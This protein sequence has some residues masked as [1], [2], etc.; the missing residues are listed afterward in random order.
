M[1][2]KQPVPGE[3]YRHFKRGG[4]YEVVGVARHT[5]TEEMLVVYRSLYADSEFPFGTLWVRPLESFMAVVEHEGSMVT[6]FTR[7]PE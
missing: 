2:S 5:E 3:V 6:R 4:T 1:E 7:V